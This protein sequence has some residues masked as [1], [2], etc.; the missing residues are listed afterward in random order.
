MLGCSVLHSAACQGFLAWTEDLLCFQTPPSPLTSRLAKGPNVEWLSHLH[1]ARPFKGVADQFQ[2]IDIRS[3]IGTIVP[4]SSV[5]ISYKLWEPVN[6]Y[7]QPRWRRGWNSARNAN[8]RKPPYISGDKV[9]AARS[10]AEDLSHSRTKLKANRCKLVY[11]TFGDVYQFSVDYVVGYEEALL[12][13]EQQGIGFRAL[14]IC[15][16]II[17]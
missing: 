2:G 7:I 5:R 10:V 13:A 4:L 1:S 9:K 6:V 17:H 14:L 12:R 3:E 16:P 11:E 8:L 15:N